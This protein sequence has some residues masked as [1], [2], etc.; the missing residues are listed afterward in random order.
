MVTLVA[1][2]ALGLPDKQRQTR[3]HFSGLC[4]PCHT[5]SQIVEIRE[6]KQHVL[7]TL[8][9]IYL[10]CFACSRV[11]SNTAVSVCQWLQGLKRWKTRTN[12]LTY[13]SLSLGDSAQWVSPNTYT[14]TSSSSI[15]IH[16]IEGI[17]QGSSQISRI[18]SHL[19]KIYF[20]DRIISTLLGRD[21]SHVSCKSPCWSLFT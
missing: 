19:S 12:W 14:H 16:R 4:T 15:I 6:R 1:E 11:S 17:R 7:S 2:G 9:Y 18:K 21:Y 5:P 20:E 13:S 3:K 10:L 8:E